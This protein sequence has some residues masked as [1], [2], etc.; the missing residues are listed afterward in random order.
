MEDIDI[1]RFKDAGADRFTVAIDCAT[2]IYLIS[3]EAM[4]L[5][6]STDGRNTGRCWRI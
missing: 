4:E 5:M 6:D 1:Q 3:I 2:K